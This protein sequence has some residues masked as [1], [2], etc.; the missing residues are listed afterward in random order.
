MK[1]F[2]DRHI[3]LSKDD[4]DKMLDKIKCK[5]VDDLKN[6]TRCHITDTNN[7]ITKLTKKSDTAYVIKSYDKLLIA[8]TDLQEALEQINVP[9]QYV[10][11]SLF[12]TKPKRSAFT[13]DNLKKKTPQQSA[14]TSAD[15]GT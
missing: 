11:P 1:Q 6:F 2:K 13:P 10:K 4:I 8:L 12:Q 7:M 5:S 3:G 14:Q 9:S 15:N